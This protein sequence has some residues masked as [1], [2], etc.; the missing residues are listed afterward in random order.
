MNNLQKLQLHDFHLNNSAKLIPFAGWE[1]PVS[2][3]RI[4]DEHMQTRDKASL[5]DV[6]HMGEIEI[7]GP[8]AEPFLDFLLTNSVSSLDSGKGVYSPM[9]SED[10][11]TIDDLI[12]YK[13]GS[14]TFLLCVNASNTDKDFEHF[15]KHKDG[16][17]CEISNRSDQFGQLAIQG[18]SSAQ[19]LFNATGVEFGDIPKMSFREIDLFGDYCLVARTGYTGEDG[20]EIYCPAER[21]V[22]WARA[23]DGNLSSGLVRWAGLAARDSL[24][25]EAGFPLY[26]HELSQEIS[27]LQAG[28]GWAIKWSKETF[29]GKECLLRE[30]E[31]GGPGKVIFYEVDDRRIPRQGD[32]VFVFDREVGRV[33]S[34]GY[35]PL[36]EGP[37]GSAWVDRSALHCKPAA[38]L[39][40][41]VR[42]K[43]VS[44]RRELPVLRKLRSKPQCGDQVSS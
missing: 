22:D 43:R 11:G 32:K 28:L 7:H 30:K 25:L 2:F 42:D 16:F 33:L 8:D 12:A 3:G 34:G 21:T 36:V 6:S 9:C 39:S 14:D 24:R 5:F 23:F 38:E 4:I 26:G 40:A 29:L 27:P 10:G 35:S 1:M 19:A 13:K 31:S 18:P 41:E 17:D 37:I 15:Q 20:F 44:L